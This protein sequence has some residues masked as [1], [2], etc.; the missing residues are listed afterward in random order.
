VAGAREVRI[1]SDILDFAGPVAF[2]EV[3]PGTYQGVCPWCA[4]D[5]AVVQ[6][7]TYYELYDRLYMPQFEHMRTCEDRNATSMK[8]KV[9]RPFES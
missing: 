5:L 9:R 3:E 1:V 4:K 6:A 8:A 2:D 7:K